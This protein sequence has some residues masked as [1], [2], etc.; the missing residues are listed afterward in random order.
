V[1][2]PS[3]TRFMMSLEESVDLVLYAL[4][5]GSN[6]EIIVQK[7]PAVTIDVLVKAL[8]SIFKKESHPID[9][10]GTRHG[11][12]MYETLLSR[13]EISA[14]IEN[15][16]FFR[17][18]PDMRDLNYRSYFDEGDRSISKHEDYTSHNT[19]RLDIDETKAMLLKLPFIQSALNGEDLLPLA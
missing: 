9:I 17:V 8:C 12:K 14:V 7:A 10:I 13:E 2:D 3:M 4:E 19:R 5:H 15:G 6:G 1:T 18:Q 16:D 11:E